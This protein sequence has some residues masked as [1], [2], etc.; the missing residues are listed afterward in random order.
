MT[1]DKFLCVVGLTFPLSMNI[2]KLEHGGFSEDISNFE[3]YKHIELDAWFFKKNHRKREGQ[4]LGT[5]EQ[6]KKHMYGLMR[7]RIKGYL[8]SLEM[9]FTKHHRP[10]WRATLGSHLASQPSPSLLNP[11]V[12]TTHPRA[13]QALGQVSAHWNYSSYIFFTFT[14]HQKESRLLCG[15]LLIFF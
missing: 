4:E 3:L 7:E 8:V 14:P 9:S 15:V 5:R 2:P 6:Q 10:S 12:M 1:S 13:E 11:I